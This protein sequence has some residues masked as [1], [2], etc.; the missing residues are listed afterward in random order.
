MTD[1]GSQHFMGC[2]TVYTRADA[3]KRYLR[4]SAQRR[5]GQLK[6]VTMRMSPGY[7]RKNGVPYSA[8]AVL[9]EYVTLLADDDNTQYLAVTTMLDDPQYLA[10]PWVR[11]SQFKKQAN[12]TGWNPMPCSAR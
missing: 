9:T 3:G 12:A 8:K 7:L 11:T 10:Q 5:V 6:V 2:V 4:G 1:F